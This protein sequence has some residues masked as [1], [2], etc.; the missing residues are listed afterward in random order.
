MISANQCSDH[1]PRHAYRATMA[2]SSKCKFEIAQITRLLANKSFSEVLWSSVQTLGGSKMSLCSWDER[3][4]YWTLSMLIDFD[5]HVSCANYSSAL[6]NFELLSISFQFKFQ[7]YRACWTSKKK[8]IP[9]KN[10]KSCRFDR[11]K[12]W[13]I[14]GEQSITFESELSSQLVITNDLSYDETG[15]S[16]L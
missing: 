6:N 8:L 10:S 7:T 1:T 14:V 4:Q 15:E 13:S 3:N 16:S 2:E 5:F 11:V 12:C 9:L